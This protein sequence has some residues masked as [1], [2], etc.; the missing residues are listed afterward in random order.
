MNPVLLPLLAILLELV[1][2]PFREEFKLEPFQRRNSNWD[3]FREGIH[4]CNSRFLKRINRPSTNSFLVVGSSALF[5]HGVEAA[6]G[7]AEAGDAAGEE[8]ED[9]GADDGRQDPPVVR[10]LRRPQVQ[11]VARVA[12]LQAGRQGRDSIGNCVGS[13]FYYSTHMPPYN[14]TV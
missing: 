4:N 3:H 14:D 10:A 12:V 2:E 5:A 11:Q 7:A 9:G 1:L 8:G 6:A 13:I